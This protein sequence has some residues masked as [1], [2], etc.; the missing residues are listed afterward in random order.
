MDEGVVEGREDVRN[1]KHQLTLSDLGPEGDSVLFLGCFNFFGGLQRTSVGQRCNPAF[2][3]IFWRI[4]R[5]IKV[6]N[7]KWK[8]STHHRGCF[9][10]WKLEDDED[11]GDAGDTNFRALES[12]S[13][14]YV[15][16]LPIRMFLQLFPRLREILALFIR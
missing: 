5:D 4:K 7:V 1:A 3:S 6:E 13:T 14:K 15:R 2:I 11:N 9:R 10:E 16:H 12:N 8:C